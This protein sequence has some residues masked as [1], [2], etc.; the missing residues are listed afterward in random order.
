M[1]HKLLLV[2]V[3]GVVM[4]TTGVAQGADSVLH[5]GDAFPALTGTA[6]SGRSISVPVAD[7][8][9]VVIMA[10]SRAAGNDARRWSEWLAAD[11][12]RADV[13]IVAELQ[14]VPRLLRGAVAFT[15]KRGVPARL[16]DR[17]LLLSSD[18]SVWKQ[19]LAVTSDAHAYVTLVDSSGR[20]RWM[21]GG[22]SDDATMQSLRVELRHQ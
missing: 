10:F 19:R 3:A 2:G 6:I 21:S 20:V 9:T 18:E 1:F 15:I 8:Q 12:S 11:S 13:V 16:R 17:M 5:V 4:A 22:V 7:H 14:S